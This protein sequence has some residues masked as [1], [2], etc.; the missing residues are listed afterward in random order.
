MELKAQLQQRAQFKKQK[1]RWI[2]E[3]GDS[4]AVGDILSRNPRQSKPVSSSDSDGEYFPHISGREVGDH[5]Q[6]L[7]EPV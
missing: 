3:F 4:V 2:E 1:E 5:V 7:I 6:P